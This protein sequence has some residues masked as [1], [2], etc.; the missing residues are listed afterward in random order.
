MRL[1]I[2]KIQLLMHHEFKNSQLEGLHELQRVMARLE[3]KYVETY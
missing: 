2:K 3:R 1:T